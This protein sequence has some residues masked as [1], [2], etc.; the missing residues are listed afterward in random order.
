M[1]IKGNAGGGVI[2]ETISIFKEDKGKTKYYRT[3]SWCNNCQQFEMGKGWTDSATGHP[4]PRE[5]VFKT[6]VA[7][8]LGAKLAAENASKSREK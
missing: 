8:K 2:N 7:V 6:D 1:K 4:I 3:I 5:P